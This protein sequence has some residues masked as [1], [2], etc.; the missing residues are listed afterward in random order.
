MAT[1]LTH[2]GQGEVSNSTEIHAS[3]A[4]CQA[5]IDDPADESDPAV[6]AL[7]LAC[8]TVTNYWYTASDIPEASC[9]ASTQL[10]DGSGVAYGPPVISPPS[11]ADFCCTNY[12]Y[13]II[14]NPAVRDSCATTFKDYAYTGGDCKAD[15]YPVF[16]DPTEDYPT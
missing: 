9:H 7:M 6:K 15:V 11:S 14:S 8:D 12:L 13:G 10:Y 4:C 1:I 16:P 3:T 2:D 5:G